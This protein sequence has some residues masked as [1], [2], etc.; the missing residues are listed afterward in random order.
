[1]VEIEIQIRG[2]MIL[3]SNASLLVRDFVCNELNKR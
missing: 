2:M 1:M 3:K